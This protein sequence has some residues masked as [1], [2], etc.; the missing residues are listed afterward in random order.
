MATVKSTSLTFRGFDHDPVEVER[1]VGVQAQRLG[2]RGL[3]VKPGVFTLLTRS[4][5]MFELSCTEDTSFDRAL[6]DLLEHL[7]GVEHLLAV[8]QRVNPEFID[9]CVT[10]GVR[11]SEEQEDSFVD[12][13]TLGALS[14]LG[15]ILSFMFPE[16]NSD[17]EG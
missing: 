13:Q 15:A 9:V 3:P 17:D 6:H 4:F 10:S 1:L 14:R 2:T 7:G 12:P 8:R 11:G 16:R 5:A